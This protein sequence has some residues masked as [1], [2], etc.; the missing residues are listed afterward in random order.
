MTEAEPSS[1]GE[2]LRQRRQAAG[3]TQEELASRSG[4][5]A[6]GI[7]ALES[8]RRR[9]PYPH[10]VRALANALG[11]DDTERTTLMGLAPSTATSPSAG[12]Q[13]AVPPAPPTPTI[14]RDEAVTEVLAHLEE[15]DSRLV[16]L[17]GPGGVGKT[18]L[19]LVV[20]RRALDAFPDG[21][22]FVPLASLTEPGLVLPTVLAAL[23]LAERSD[24]ATPD[25]LAAYLQGRRLLLVLDNL[26]HLL[27]VATELAA[28]LAESPDL[29]ILATSRS[30]LRI[31]GER[32]YPVTPLVLPKLGHL[33]T[34]DEVSAADAVQLFVERARASAPNFALTQDNAA[35]VAAIC[36]RLDGL[37][38]ALELAA[39]R[40]RLLSP[41]ELLARIDQAL[42]LLSG[43]ARD[44]P[45]R[46]RTMQQTIAWS[47]QLLNEAEQALFRRL[48]FFA[49]GW[50]AAAAEAVGAGVD[51]AGGYTLDILSALVEHSLV[52]ADS[53]GG[54]TRYRMLETIREFGRTQLDASGE[55][56]EVARVHA[57]W[58]LMLAE[59]AS[60]N[61]F[62]PSEADWLDRL[63]RD[64]PNLRTAVIHATQDEDEALL[65]RLV[66]ALG[67]FWHK[68]ERFG[69][70]MAWMDHAIRI[71]RGTPPSLQGASVLFNAGRLA[72]DRGDT[73]TGIALLR[74]SLATSR[75]VGDET[76][77]CSA[78][79]IL[80]DMLRLRG[81]R[82]EAEDLMNEVQ[83]SLDRLGSE[84]FSSTAL[85]LLGIMALEKGDWPKAEALM[86]QALATA[87]ESRYQW[88]IAAALHNLGHL[89]HLR[90]DHP[91]SLGLYLESLRISYEQRDRWSLAVTL[92]ALA[93]VFVAVGETEKAVR[94]FG[95]TSSLSEAIATR[96]VAVTPVVDGYEQA[97]SDVR[98]ALGD[99]A[100][101]SAWNEGRMLTPQR[102][103]EEAARLIEQRTQAPPP[104]AQPQALPFGLSTREV[105][106]L[107]LVAE[108]MTNAQVA[109][110]LYL[111]RRT[112]DA[113][114]RR[115]YDKL[116]L[117]SRAEVIQFV[118]EH[119]LA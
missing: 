1:F 85:R 53:S 2:R 21:V 93:E 25:D 79:I 99:T 42:P 20:A 24:H 40:M 89:V 52:V 16:T 118:T 61:Y 41:T 32:E 50:D 94:L 67:R 81:E 9:R 112:V 110:R 63:E 74:E 54:T 12:F 8:G 87:R 86:A 44:L 13:M 6:K 4:L 60:A 57:H 95:A 116:N 103:I 28:L 29:K 108:G 17:T 68:R 82:S 11:L 34:R 5:T 49:G 37:P 33:P 96:L 3:L 62:A 72:W 83:P 107:Q 84:P 58:Y 100:F 47:Y 36:R 109:E 18:R 114:L 97:I 88:S 39:A 92:P 111:S 106:V 64:H 43:G 90:G 78:A 48:S 69:E 115:I 51:L 7:A 30:P 56:S 77:A 38:L 117:S 119:R 75:R 71:V 80:A 91:R 55:T 46:Q 22:L 101:E 15:D 113:H 19:S 104:V 98:K 76:G 23:G 105:E 66:A 35:A 73:A 10:T 31:R 27:P 26:E 59:E 14:G 102:A 70:E 45:E 65:L